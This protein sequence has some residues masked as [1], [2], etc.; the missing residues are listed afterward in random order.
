MCACI[1]HWPELC[2]PCT[3]LSWTDAFFSLWDARALYQQSV[4]GL[5]MSKEFC[6]F[7]FP[8]CYH[9]QPKGLAN[10]RKCKSERHGKVLWPPLRMSLLSSAF[11]VSS[12][13]SRKQ[14]LVSQCLWLMQFCYILPGP[15]FESSDSLCIGV[16]Q[17]SV[18]MG[19]G[20]HWGCKEWQTD[21]DGFA[22]HMCSSFLSYQ[23]SLLKHKFN[24]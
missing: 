4:F 20:T 7:P 23:S 3:N 12:S 16:H 13:S 18:F 22:S 17:T 5:F 24:D 19:P 1:V 14:G 2:K 6:I 15:C 8:V 11:R 21:M 9:F 10:P